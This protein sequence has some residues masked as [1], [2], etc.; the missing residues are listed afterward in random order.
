[1][2]GETVK[3]RR[4]D[5][6]YLVSIEMWCCRR[7]EKVSWSDRVRNS[8]VLHSVKVRNILRAVKI[9]KVN[10]AGHILRRNCLLKRVIEGKIEEFYVRV[11]VHRDM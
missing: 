3:L 8:E 7:V 9:R 5:Q 11:T 6:I 2:H 10:W 4:G 1:M